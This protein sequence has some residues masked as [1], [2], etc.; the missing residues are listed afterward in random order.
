MIKLSTIKRKK[1]TS[2]QKIKNRGKVEVLDELMEGIDNV[3]NTSEITIRPKALIDWM[4][5][6]RR[7][8]DT[9]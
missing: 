5:D 1:L 7:T 6:L 8:Y 9:E 4:E 3:W 2:Y